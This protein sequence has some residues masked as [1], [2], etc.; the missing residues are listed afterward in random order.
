MPPSRRG[1]KRPAEPTESKDMPPSRR[2]SKRPVETWRGIPLVRPCALDLFCGGGGAGRGLLDAGYKTVIGIDHERHKPSYEHT[3]GLHFLLGDVYDIT[4]DDLGLFDLVW[5]SPPC[6]LYTGII[7]RAQREKHQARWEAQGKH[8]NHIP[9]IREMLKKSGRDYIIENVPNAPLENF[10]KLCGTHFGLNVF[11]HRIFES[12]VPLVSPGPCDHKN[13][14]TSGLAK[15][16][17]QPKTER[18]AEACDAEH[19]P[20]GVEQVAVCYPCRKEERNDYIYR[21][22]TPEMK[23]I[24]RKTYGRGYA[25]SLKELGRVVGALVP[26]T[27]EER[28]AE[29]ERYDA[30]RKAKLKPGCEEMFSVYGATSKHRGTTPEWQQAMGCA[31][32]NREELCQAIPPA[33]S[34]Y[35]GKQVL[36]RAGGQ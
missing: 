23:E 29:V 13:K 8:L 12:N 32:M 1:S 30:E 6:Q 10:V 34:E 9:Q 31:W 16:V 11:R 18:Y 22:T 4:H 20:D 28:A 25:R 7:P 3:P 2:G 27:D 14:C 35:L 21:G 5:A 15:A 19:L 36:Q 26:M 24:F 33:Y 17:R